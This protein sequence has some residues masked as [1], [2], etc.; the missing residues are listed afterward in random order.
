MRRRDFIKSSIGMGTAL[1]FSSF[2]PLESFGKKVQTV[3]RPDL[4]VVKD[5][6]PGYMVRKAMELLGGMKNFV[7]TG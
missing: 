5:G 2:I 3:S 6:A 7:S 1:G 4:A